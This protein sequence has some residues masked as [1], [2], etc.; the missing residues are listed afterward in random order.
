[1]LSNNSATLPPAI[2]MINGQDATMLIQNLNL[3]FSGFQDPDSQWNSVFPNYAS[4]EAALTV[5]GS[6]AFQGPSLTLTYENGQE[7]TQESFAI[8]RASADFTGVQ[9]GE[10]FYNRFCNPELNPVRTMPVGDVQPQIPDAPPGAAPAPVFGPGLTPPRPGYPAPVVRDSGSNT[11]SGY[12]L[13]G[14]GHDDVAVLSV[15]SFAPDGNLGPVEYLS[16]FQ[17][18]VETF[19]SQCRD[20]NKQRLVVDLSANGGGFVIAG[21]DLFAQLFPDAPRFQATNLRL[22]ESLVGIAQGLDELPPDQ[23]PANDLERSAII[24]LATSALIGNFIPGEVFK[25]SGEDFQSIQSILAPVTLNGD[26]FSAYQQSPLTQPNLDFNLTGV[27]S[28]AMPPPAVFAPEN[29]VLLTDG[30]CGSTC[31]LFAY[32]AILGLGVKT[33]VMGG[34]PQLGPMQAIAGVEGAQVFFFNDMQ[35]DAAAILA[36]SPPEKRRELEGGEMGELARGYAIARAR[37]Q[38]L[39]GAVNGKNAFMPSD[40]KTPLQFLFQPANCRF[41]YTPQMVESAEAAWRMAVDATWTDP[42]GLCVEGSRTAPNGTTQG[43]GN[44]DPAFTATDPGMLDNVNVDGTP[45]PS[46]NGEGQRVDQPEQSGAA[47]RNIMPVVVLAWALAATVCM[48]I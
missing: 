27:G 9:N 46:G 34:R 1:M 2:T 29:V 3:Q 26:D 35:A 25:P 31:T 13:Q 45:P 23:Q 30:T 47:R 4:P 28:R 5:A 38:D 36:L 6:I 7:R 22:A 15:S 44:I 18:T 10:D 17:R 42:A 11:T 12:F 41:Y 20:Q 21:F 19:L 48:M 37:D 40:A 32:F 43:G 33:A 8:I 39:A 14:A 16:D 24:Q